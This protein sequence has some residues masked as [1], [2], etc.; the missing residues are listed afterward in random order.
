MYAK[1]KRREY[2]MIKLGKE[3]SEESQSEV[4]QN[5]KKKILEKIERTKQKDIKHIKL[6]FY[7]Q[8]YLLNGL[9]KLRNL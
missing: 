9:A 8:F 6:N 7:M 1:D 4:K 2:S 5:K 3:L